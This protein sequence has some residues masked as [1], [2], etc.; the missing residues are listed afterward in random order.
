MIVDKIREIISLRQ[1]KGLE[2]CIKFITQKTNQ[3]VNDFEED[4]YKFTQYWILS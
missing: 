3:A 1:N 4:F 2:K